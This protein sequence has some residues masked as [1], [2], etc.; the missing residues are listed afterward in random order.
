[1]KF[2][3]LILLFS[4][5]AFPDQKHNRGI[6][7]PSIF[8][9]NMV[10]QQNSFV[11]FWGKAEQKLEVNIKSGWGESA[12]TIVDTDGN[13]LAKLKT[14]SAGGPYEI[15]LQIGD[16][17]INYKNVLIGE[18][19]FCSGQ[20]NM[21]MPL[22]GW[23]PSD[24]ISNS[25]EEIA[26]ANYPDIRLFTVQRSFSNKKEFNIKGSREICNPE[27]AGNFSATA[28]FFGRKLYEEL[29]NGNIGKIPIGLINSSWGGTPVE[30]WISDKYLS[31][32]SQF[33]SIL[34][35]IKSSGGEIERYN[36][37][38]ETHKVIDINAG[39][40]EAWENLEFDDE[41]CSLINFD[42][43]AW[44][45]MNL[46]TLW[47]NTEVGNFDGVVWF[48]KKIEIPD[49]WVNKDLVL[50]LGSID[51]MDKTYVNGTPVGAYEQAGF[52]STDRIYNIPKELLT[53]NELLIAVRVIDNQGGGGIY[54]DKEKL[55]IYPAD[56]SHII[57]G[58]EEFIP[59]NGNWKYLPVAEYRD[60]K[61]F[62]FGADKNDYDLKPYVRINLSAYTPTALFNG[63]VNPLIPYSIKGAIW[64]QGESNT[65]NPE[66][67]STLFPLMISNWRDEWESDEFPFYFV[68]IAPYNY[69]DLTHSERLREAQLKSLSV[70]YTGMVVT[71]DIGN[72]DNIHPANKKD[73]GERLARWALAK[74]YNK[75]IPYSGPLFKSLK[76]E[77]NKIIL[78]FD[79]T[80]DSLVLKEKNGTNNFLIAG[81]DKK[82]IKAI[83][84]VEEYN[85]IV[86]NPEIENPEAVRYCWDNIAEATL[87]NSAGLPASSFRTDNWKE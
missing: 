87:F 16:S 46:P 75:N 31:T 50:E 30:S 22:Q 28:Y 14:P 77:E 58:Q 6:E 34:N 20:S 48:R 19:W 56:S 10:L 69:G 45:E 36:Q 81:K 21:E 68:Q 82:F 7:I 40:E 54:S 33:D 37:W 47:E 79:Y 38:L 27:N 74:S 72:P 43:I 42:D 59:L 86:Y 57:T 3:T 80:G 67:Y 25:S 41:A 60:Q 4:T 23:P 8:S 2:I 52:W 71:L 70:P 49:A 85:L 12:T 11:S 53:N 61:F 26:N 66:M 39:S 5:M 84:K 83:V 78:S 9:D 29:S 32:V 13:W 17:I 15:N 44:K 65:G 64:Y 73:V 76:T 62:V 18:V 24:T 1:M 55:K 51:D 63:M 35:D